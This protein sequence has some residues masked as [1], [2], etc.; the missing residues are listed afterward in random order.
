MGYRKRN[1]H[2]DNK[3]TD[4]CLFC[5]SSRFE[6]SEGKPVVFHGLS[7]GCERC[8][9]PGALHVEHPGMISGYDLTI[10]NP[11]KLNRRFE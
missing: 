1:R 11:A 5:H 6:K 8:H 10:V 7:I 3:V 2:F 9:G 4:K